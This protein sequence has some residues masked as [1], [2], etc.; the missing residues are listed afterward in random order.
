MNTNSSLDRRPPTLLKHLPV[1]P[2]RF[3]SE[4]SWPLDSSQQGECR[5]A[6]ATTAWGP[7]HIARR[8]LYKEARAALTSNTPETRRPA[9]LGPAAM[10]AP[11]RDAFQPSS[12][13]SSYITAAKRRVVPSPNMP[14][15]P[16]GSAT[17]SNQTKHKPGIIGL[18][19]D[20]PR[21]WKH[22]LRDLQPAPD[23]C[24]HPTPAETRC[25]VMTNLAAQAERISGS[26]LI[27]TYLPTPASCQACRRRRGWLDA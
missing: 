15:K 7:L 22:V 14:F 3:S 13:C 17:G 18:V 12:T 27:I 8:R 26:T 2:P 16:D 24:T 21:S 11:E 6:L 20:V 1:A 23:C 10:L 4:P 9:S 25:Y 19:Q 5:Y